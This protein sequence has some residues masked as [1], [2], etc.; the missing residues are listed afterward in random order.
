M[1]YSSVVYAGSVAAPARQRD[2]IAA[3]LGSKGL[4]SSSESGL[5]GQPAS[6]PSTLP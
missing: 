5:T 2:L 4:F 1:S 6:A 3:V